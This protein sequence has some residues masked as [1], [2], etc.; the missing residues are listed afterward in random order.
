M[1]TGDAGL[2]SLI[3]SKLG[4]K[5]TGHHRQE[6]QRLSHM[7]QNTAAQGGAKASRFADASQKVPAAKPQD[8]RELMAQRV[9]SST[10]YKSSSIFIV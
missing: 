6:Q 2:F 4:A 9:C 1:E 5:P 10:V 8:R 7:Q 3:N